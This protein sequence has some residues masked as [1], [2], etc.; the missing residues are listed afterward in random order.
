MFDATAEFQN[1]SSNKNILKGPDYLNSLIG[2]LLRFRRGKFAAMADIE[3]MYRQIKVKESDQDAL[4]FVWRNTPEEEIKDHNMT[5]HIFG[6][7][8]SPCR[9]NW[10]IKRKASDQFNKYRVN[11][12]NT[13]HESFNMDDYLDCFSSEE[14]AIDI[15][16]KVISILSNGGFRLT[17]WLS[18]NKNI[19]KAVLTTERSPKIVNLNLDNTPVERALGIIRDPQEDMLRIKDVTKNVVL[20]K[21]ELLSF[22]NSIYDPVGLIAPVTLEP[23]LIIQDL[24]RRQIDWHV[25]LPDD[26]KLRWTKWK[27]TL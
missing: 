23:K 16:Q 26:L 3:Q 2:I 6:K 7:I 11:I 20:T 19:L 17:K 21:T 22:T 10:V 13:I 18:N 25:E 1:T 5:V 24:W 9:A 14:R 12:I 4:R 27:Q 15:I 8:D